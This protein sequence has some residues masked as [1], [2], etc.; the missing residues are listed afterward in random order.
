MA[1]ANSFVLPPSTQVLVFADFN[2]VDPKP[3]TIAESL[4]FK[5]DEVHFQRVTNLSTLKAFRDSKAI[6]SPNLRYLIVACLSPI[7][8]DSLDEILE[9]AE[10]I[11]LCTFCW[12][13]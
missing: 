8:V 2:F 13:A 10:D 9:R 6:A 3:H 1:A 12:Y 5:T 11:G 7:L 4:K